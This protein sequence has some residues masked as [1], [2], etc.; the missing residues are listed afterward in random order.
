VN[1]DH[2]KY[3]CFWCVGDQRWKTTYIEFDLR[4]HLRE[5]HRMDMVKLPIGRGNMDKRISYAAGHCKRVT[6]SLRENP[7]LRKILVT[8]KKVGEDS[9]VYE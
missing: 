4:Q 2:L 8:R 1:I 9:F 6:I 3:Y 7:E 5:K